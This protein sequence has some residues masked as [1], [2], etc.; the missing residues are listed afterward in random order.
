MRHSFGTWHWA[1]HRHEGE[2]AIQLGDTIKT[3]KTHYVN[4]RVRERD[5]SAYWDI[6]PKTEANIV[7]MAKVG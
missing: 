1:M 4:T 2:T 7:H 5:A 6:A 3:V